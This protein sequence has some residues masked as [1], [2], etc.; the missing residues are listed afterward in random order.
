VHNLSGHF[1]LYQNRCPLL[2]L[3][4]SPLLP[5]R[6]SFHFSSFQTFLHFVFA[7]KGFA[8]YNFRLPFISPSDDTYP[9]RPLPECLH[10]RDPHCSRRGVGQHARAPGHG[11]VGPRVAMYFLQ[12]FP[13]HIHF[14]KKK[15]F[16]QCF[17]C[18]FPSVCC[19]DYVPQI[20]GSKIYKSF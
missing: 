19:C 13:P 20:I 16:P 18:F 6:L 11:L 1:F 17:A 3:T 12:V 7:S 15:S 2:S 9:T 8:P 14:V 4:L 5:T 10:G